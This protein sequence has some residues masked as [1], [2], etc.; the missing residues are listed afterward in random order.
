M[1][2]ELPQS[3]KLDSSLKEGAYRFIYSGYSLFSL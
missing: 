2:Y 1:S 3:S